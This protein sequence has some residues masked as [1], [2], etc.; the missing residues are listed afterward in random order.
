MNLMK[1]K[2]VASYLK[3]GYWSQRAIN[4]A[5]ILCPKVEFPAELQV[6]N[7]AIIIR[8]MNK[9]N[10]RY[11]KCQNGMSPQIQPICIIVI[12]KQ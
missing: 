4:E 12:T 8:E 1:G 3:T 5:N 10:T 11:Q 7:L 2:Q 9:V 6:H